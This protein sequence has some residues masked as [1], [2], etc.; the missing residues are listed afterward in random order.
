MRPPHS[1]LILT[2]RYRE[3]VRDPTPDQVAGAIAELGTRRE[4][5]KHPNAWLRLGLSDGRVLMLDAYTSGTVYFQMFADPDD[6]DPVTNR[7]ARA[8]AMDGI[9]KLFKMLAEGDVAGLNEA[10]WENAV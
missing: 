1:W 5:T 9:E 3:D 2:T 8:L 4:D 6:A 7:M 10:L